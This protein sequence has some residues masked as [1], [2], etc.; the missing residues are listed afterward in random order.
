MKRYILE[1]FKKFLLFVAIFAATTPSQLS[2][3]QR[4]VPEKLKKYHI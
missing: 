3:Y 2:Y 4:E 1:I